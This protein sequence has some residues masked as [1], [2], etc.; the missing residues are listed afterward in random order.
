VKNP[1]LFQERRV[2]KRLGLY[3]VLGF[4]VEKKEGNKKREKKSGRKILCV[5]A[6]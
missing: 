5:G 6:Q 2:K 1:I 3:S 4:R